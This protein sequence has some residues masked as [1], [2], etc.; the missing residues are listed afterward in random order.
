M[1]RMLALETLVSIQLISLTSRELRNFLANFPQTNLKQV[2][3]QL[4]SLTS[5]EMVQSFATNIAPSVSIQLISL[6]SR[7][8]AGRSKSM[9]RS[10]WPVS[11]QLISLTSREH[12][13][14]HFR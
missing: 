3:I 11:I 7:E 4:I 9:G 14:S 10:F 2:S 6:T 1:L 5:R 12:I 13:L 8:D